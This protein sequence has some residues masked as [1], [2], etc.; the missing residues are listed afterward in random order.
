VQVEKVVV[1]EGGQVGM[2]EVREEVV[3]VERRVAAVLV[4]VVVVAEEGQV[5]AEV[6]GWEREEE[7]EKEVVVVRVVEKVAGGVQEVGWTGKRSCL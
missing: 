2:V 7:M 5:G 1:T 3:V 6:V 4:V